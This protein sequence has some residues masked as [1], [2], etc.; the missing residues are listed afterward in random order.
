MVRLFKEIISDTETKQ[1]II[2][3]ALTT[4]IFIIQ[5]IIFNCINAHK[6]VSGITHVRTKDSSVSTKIE[7][8]TQV[9]PKYYGRPRRRF[10]V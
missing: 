6:S 2:L 8:N 10:L 7:Q 1:L 3:T 5:L 4:I 9:N